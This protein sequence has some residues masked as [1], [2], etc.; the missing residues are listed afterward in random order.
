M[1][2]ER[3]EPVARGLYGKCDPDEARW[4]YD[5]IRAGHPWHTGEA[6]LIVELGCYEGGGTVIL[7]AA[8]NAIDGY[9]IPVDGYNLWKVRDIE[10]HGDPAERLV[11]QSAALEELGLSHR[12]M[13][14][15]QDT[16][17][18]GQIFRG[19][20]RIVFLHIDA[21]HRYPK[22]VEDFRLWSTSVVPGGIVAFHD[23]TDVAVQRS[24][25]E[26][27]EAGYLNGWTKLDLHILSR[28]V[29]DPVDYRRGSDRSLIAFRVHPEVSVIH[30]L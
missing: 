14:A 29:S 1:E 24:I 25:E 3:A 20:G 27:E 5:S 30:D 12:V 19:L 9:V 18:A 8:A 23:V 6:P 26:L 13:P 15:V 21:D 10:D 11:K 2:Y 17:I 22:P 4:W 28:P 7:A 16:S